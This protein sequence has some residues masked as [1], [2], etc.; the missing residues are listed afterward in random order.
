MTTKRLTIS[1]SVG[2]K[3]AIEDCFIDGDMNVVRFLREGLLTRLG[4]ESKNS[5]EQGQ[6]QFQEIQKDGKQEAKPYSLKGVNLE[7]HRLTSDSSYR[8][9]GLKAEDNS[10]IEVPIGFRL[11]DRLETYAQIIHLRHE[12][13]GVGFDKF[14]DEQLEK[15]KIE[16]PKDAKGIKDTEK[17][18]EKQ[19]HARLES[20]PRSLEEALYPMIFAEIQKKIDEKELEFIQQE[21]KELAEEESQALN[22]PPTA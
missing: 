22:P 17:Q 3:T 6:I 12:L 18:V 13:F 9:N 10:P 11:Y 16:K 7:E 15:F 1:M 2:T 21:N 14:F 19:K 20:I 5:I 8:P 4:I